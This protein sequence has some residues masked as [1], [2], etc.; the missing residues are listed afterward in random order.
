MFG[1]KE[2]SLFHECGGAQVF[3][4]GLVIIIEMYS[5][6]RPSYSTCQCLDTQIINT[7]KLRCFKYFQFKKK[8]Q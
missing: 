1:N 5:P 6:I 7:L 2:M 3:V 4:K 8:K